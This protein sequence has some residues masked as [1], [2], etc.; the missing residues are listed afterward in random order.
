MKIFLS[1][2]CSEG[3]KSGSIGIAHYS[4]PKKKLTENFL[5][6]FYE[7]SSVQ[8][9]IYRVSMWHM[10]IFWVLRNFEF[11]PANGIFPQKGKFSIFQ[12]VVF[13]GCDVENWVWTKLVLW[14]CPILWIRIKIGYTQLSRTFFHY[15]RPIR[16]IYH[17]SKKIIFPKKSMIFLSKICSRGAQ[18][19][20]MGI[21]R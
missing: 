14:I 2:I 20:S 5:L 10:G 16:P 8:A 4:R 19:G 13:L 12:K 18:S 15:Y 6:S 3:L 11:Q 17:T 9:H 7:F 1:T 21:E